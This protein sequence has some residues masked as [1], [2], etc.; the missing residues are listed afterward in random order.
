MIKSKALRIAAV[1]G[2]LLFLAL[3]TLLINLVFFPLRCI[4]TI[5][6]EMILLWSDWGYGF[7]WA[8]YTKRVRKEKG[9]LFS[10]SYQ[11]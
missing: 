9:R 2:I 7:T 1:V 6:M 8:N 5:P 4:F 3:P 11:L 10:F